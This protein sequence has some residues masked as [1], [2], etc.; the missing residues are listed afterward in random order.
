MKRLRRAVSFS[1]VNNQINQTN[2]PIACGNVKPGIL[3]VRTVK[4]CF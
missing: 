1:L 2:I 4:I 3:F